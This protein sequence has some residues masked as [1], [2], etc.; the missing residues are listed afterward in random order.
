M[1]NLKILSFT[2]TF[3]LF[4]IIT[5]YNLGLIQQQRTLFDYKNYNKGLIEFIFWDPE[6]K[7]N[8]PTLI[9]HP[10]THQSWHHSRIQDIMA[11]PYLVEPLTCPGASSL[12]S[13]FSRGENLPQGHYY[14]SPQQDW[15]CCSYPHKRSICLELIE[16]HIWTFWVRVWRKNWRFF[17][18]RLSTSVCHP[19][20]TTLFQ[21]VLN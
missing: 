9:T 4:L 13:I 8:Q 2:L 6:P 15:L 19:A 7:N 11:D 21:T 20:A 18:V 14:R 16:F 1:Q 12:L 3:R 5:H 10:K 17:C